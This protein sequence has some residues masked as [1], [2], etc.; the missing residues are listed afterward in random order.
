MANA[1]SKDVAQ[2]A[3]DVAT[4]SDGEAH[5]TTAASEELSATVVQRRSPAHGSPDGNEFE[6]NGVAQRHESTSSARGVAEAALPLLTPVSGGLHLAPFLLPTQVC[7]SDHSSITSL[8]TKLIEQTV[9][10]NGSKDP[11]A[12]ADTVRRYVRNEV[13]YVLRDKAMRASE[14]L[15]CGEGMCTNKANLQTALLRAAGVPAGY[16]LVHITRDAYNALRASVVSE[17]V[18][19]IHEP[20]LHVF[21]AV[22]DAQR[23]RFLHFDATEP[24]IVPGYPGEEIG[25]EAER[26]DA[27]NR[28]ALLCHDAA[29]GETRMQKQWLRGPLSPVQSNIDHLLTLIPYRKRGKSADY[30]ALLERTNTQLRQAHTALRMRHAR[31]V[32]S[33]A[34]VKEAAT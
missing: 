23:G 17:L 14:T 22:Y 27:Y 1:D 33:A 25:I 2:R 6:T 5:R 19:Q 9:S 20:T 4:Q 28:L 11:L 24:E 8:A 16:V 29:T 10:I 21:C 32:R 3:V 13:S 18:A 30:Q 15:A 12:V 26:D 31:T 34:D 7:D